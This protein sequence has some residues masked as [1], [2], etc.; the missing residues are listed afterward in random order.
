MKHSL[1]LLR[2]TRIRPDDITLRDI[3][4]MRL[5]EISGVIKQPEASPLIVELPVTRPL[6]GKLSVLKVLGDRKFQ[7]LDRLRFFLLWFKLMI[8]A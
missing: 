7:F 5:D 6:H 4:I 1:H 3:C 8:I 2:H